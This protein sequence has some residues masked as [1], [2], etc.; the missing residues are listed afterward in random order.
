MQL[1]IPY[2]SLIPTPPQ[3]IALPFAFSKITVATLLLPYITLNAN[4]RTENEGR[5]G[6][7]AILTVLGLVHFI[8]W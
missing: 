6:N 4:Q 2:S 5:P 1:L 3:F 7:E 8:T